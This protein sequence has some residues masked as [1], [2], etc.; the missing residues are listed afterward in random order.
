[1]KTRIATQE[2]SKKLIDV[3]VPRDKRENINLPDGDPYACRLVL[4]AATGEPLRNREGALLCSAPWLE[5]MFLFNKISLT[6]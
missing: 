2:E 4:D 3:T 1:M 5:S 6:Q